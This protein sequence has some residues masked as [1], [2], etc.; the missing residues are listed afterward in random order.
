MYSRP[1]RS[2]L[3]NW[4]RLSFSGCRSRFSNIVL[5]IQI[6]HSISWVS[7]LLIGRSKSLPLQEAAGD[8]VL[9]F[10]RQS[11]NCYSTIVGLVAYLRWD[12]EP[13]VYQLTRLAGI[14]WAS[15]SFI[16]PSIPLKSLVSRKAGTIASTVVKVRRWYVSANT[17]FQYA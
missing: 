13:R 9:K 4:S 8:L 14:R 15:T 16:S 12:M 10:I 5:S 3:G 7:S 11:M 1:C 2:L 6:F 17:S